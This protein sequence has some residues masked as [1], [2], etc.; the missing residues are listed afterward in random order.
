[1][2]ELWSRVGVVSSREVLYDDVYLYMMPS[3]NCVELEGGCMPKR[4]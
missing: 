4:R 2:A 1:M 3:N